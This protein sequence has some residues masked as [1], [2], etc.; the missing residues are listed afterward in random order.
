MLI[1]CEMQ[2]IRIETGPQRGAAVII[3]EHLTMTYRDNT[4]FKHFSGFILPF[5]FPPRQNPPAPGSPSD[6]GKVRG[7]EVE[8][9][10]DSF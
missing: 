10:K 6:V 1:C 8:V 9:C 7:D 4:V 3:S 2:H 5:L